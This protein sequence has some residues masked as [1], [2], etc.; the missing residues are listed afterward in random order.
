M[1]HQGIY[2]FGGKNKKGKPTNNLFILKLGSKPLKFIIPEVLG[3][4]PEKR[5]GHTM[6]HIQEHNMLLIYGGRNDDRYKNF[7]TAVL[8]DIHILKLKYMVWCRVKIGLTDPGPK[9]HFCSIYDS[10]E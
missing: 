1:I 10:K 6:E 3:Y 5:Y 7:G 9:Y 2:F 4:P 8:S